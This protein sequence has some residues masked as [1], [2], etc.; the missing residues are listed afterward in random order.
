M[1]FLHF[2]QAQDLPLR[3]SGFPCD[4][5]FKA[6]LVRD[7]RS[8]RKR[9]RQILGEFQTEVVRHQPNPKFREN[10]PFEARVSLSDYKV[11]RK[12][13]KEDSYEILT[14]LPFLCRTSG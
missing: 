10:N 3:D 1:N 12:T 2:Q 14:I 11:I 8:L 4:P 9:S 6:M 7:R 5:F 13:G